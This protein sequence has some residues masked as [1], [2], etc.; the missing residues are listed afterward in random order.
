MPL[1][2][3]PTGV[4]CL[5][6]ISARDKV[7]DQH[8]ACADQVAALYGGGEFDIYRTRMTFCA[9]LLGSG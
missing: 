4:V 6:E 7:W 3:S 2:V 9:D 1:S 5:G 8:K